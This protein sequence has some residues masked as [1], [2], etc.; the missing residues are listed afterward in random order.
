MNRR[1]LPFCSI[2]FTLAAHTQELPSVKEKA[3]AYVNTLA[4]PDMHGRGYVLGGDSLAAEWV[5]Q[6]F[7]RLGLGKL[8]GQRFEPFTFPVNTFPDSVRLNVDGV[9]L[10]PGV[11]F[12]T[13]PA[14]GKADGE[15]HLVH[16]TL[17]DLVTPERRAMTMGV[18]S[19]HAAYLDFPLT[20]N[21]DSLARYA[22]LE[23]EVVR[24]A[25]VIRKAQGKLTWSV[26]GEQWRNAVLEVKPGLISDSAST[27]RLRVRPKLIGQ[28]IAR[29]VFGVVE[30][31]GGSKDWIVIT[32]HGDHLGL[33]GPD[34][35]FP[36]ANDNAS[37]TSMMLC[38]AEEIKQHPLKKNVLFISF[39]G[40]EAGL[41]GS[42]WCVTDRPLDF[43][44]ITMLI[45]LDLNGTGDEGITVVNSTQ[46]QKLF[47]QL[48]TIND[49]THGLAK[50]NPRGPACNSD[51]CPFAQKGVPAVF[52]YTLG[53]ITA[54]H[55]V[56]DKP[57]T[58]PLT[59]FDELYRTLVELLGT[60]K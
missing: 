8:N 49:R 43:A 21:R 58:L 32:A 35:L 5:A 13:D 11:D 31:T 24:Y 28:H 17:E 44:R 52:I 29:N 40:E 59:K 33:M 54:Y 60:L 23:K 30:A 47:D 38:L 18:I 25:P 6:Q 3:R 42:E 27:V 41:K 56:F 12:I 1:L 57:E 16:L 39:A 51:H 48:V 14:S 7:E 2:L 50:V 15:Y 10:Q 34:V 36:G 46:Q 19:G 45:N 37:G 20:T 22:E 53:G 55:D 9:A 4:G 26:A